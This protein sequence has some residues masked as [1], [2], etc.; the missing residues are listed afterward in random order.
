MKHFFK[1]AAAYAIDCLTCYAVV[2]LVLQLGL[3]TP[4][5]TALGITE[6]WFFSSLN[7]WSY[8]LLTISL[9]VWSYFSYLDSERSKGTFGKR[10]LKLSVRNEDDT[11]VHLGKSWQ[12]TLL[13]LAPWEI[14][15]I[16]VIFPTPVYFAE[17]P[18]VR[19][20]TIVGMLLFV[21]FMA[22][23]LIGTSGQSIYDKWLRTKVIETPVEDLE[24]KV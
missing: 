19:I 10:I 16:G 24:L 3:L 12:R 22:S 1:R 5:R 14:A 7:M 6:A 17:N 2:M 8:V 23:V 9:P 20:L 4:L 15:H 11:A 13:K 21:I 18:G